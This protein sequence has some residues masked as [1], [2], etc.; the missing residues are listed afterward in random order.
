[1]DPLLKYIVNAMKCPLCG[2][3][4]EGSSHWFYCVL[5]ADHYTVCIPGEEP[6]WLIIS[7]KVMLNDNARQYE[8]IQE[9]NST[10][11]YIWEIDAEG[12]RVIE[13]KTPPTPFVYQKKLFNFSQ[14]N[15]EK[16]VNKVK[17][18]LVFQ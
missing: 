16:I 6:P 3:Q 10:A 11:I 12:R 2:G 4:I 17:T 1:M 5:N 7:E 15:R 9:P 13:K 18:I 8:I 14:T